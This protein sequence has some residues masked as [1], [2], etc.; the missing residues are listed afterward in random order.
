M[1][2]KIDD[3]RKSAGKTT[4]QAPGSKKPSALLDL[5][6]KEVGPFVEG[7]CVSIPRDTEAARA[8]EGLRQIGRL[9]QR[10][11]LSLPGVVGRRPDGRGWWVKAWDRTYVELGVAD[12]G[13]AD[14]LREVARDVGVQ[15]GSSNLLGPSR[16]LADEQRRVELQAMARLEPRVRQVAHDLVVAL[17]EAWRRGR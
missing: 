10:L 5:E 8:V 13:S 2:D 16:A 14:E 1:P 6:A 3:P 4:G 15:L 9:P 11:L 7:S 17:T 12:L